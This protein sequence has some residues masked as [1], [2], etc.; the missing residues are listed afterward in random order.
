MGHGPDS[1]LAVEDV[2]ELHRVIV[3]ELV[4]HSFLMFHFITALDAKI[5]GLEL[6]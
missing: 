3:T 6:R 1:N 5:R 2:E 4:V